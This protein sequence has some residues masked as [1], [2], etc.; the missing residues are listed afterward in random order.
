MA[1]WC[2]ALR[3]S[4]CRYWVSRASSFIW[5]WAR[6]SRYWRW[7][8]LASCSEAAFGRVG[9]GCS[10]LLGARRLQLSVLIWLPTSDYGLLLQVS[11][12]NCFK[13]TQFYNLSSSFKLFLTIL[14]V[15]TTAESAGVGSAQ[16]K[17]SFRGFPPATVQQRAVV[18][19][20]L[21][22]LR[23]A[24]CLLGPPFFSFFC[25]LIPVKMLTGA[26]TIHGR[27][28]R[29]LMEIIADVCLLPL[30]SVNLLRLS[31]SM[32]LELFFLVRHP[33]FPSLLLLTYLT[34]GLRLR[35]PFLLIS[36]IPSFWDSAGYLKLVHHTDNYGDNR[37]PRRRTP[38]KNEFQGHQSFP[39]SLEWSRYFLI[40]LF[41]TLLNN[42]PNS[43]LQLMSPL[44]SS[45]RRNTT[46]TSMTATLSS[47][48][49][50]SSNPPPSPSLLL[51]ANILVDTANNKA[52][53]PIF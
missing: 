25:R 44:P 7:A 53:F 12:L 42:D 23:N 22:L 13:F 48:T 35:L 6:S 34:F 41:H 37:S 28:R 36:R 17:I 33:F 11:A 40:T 49:N 45:I 31:W 39:D 24:L 32:P 38:F 9:G 51:D 21:S 30:R 2:L 5:S 47:M 27:S 43:K 50:P 18:E 8:C 46:R 29:G 16:P 14:I 15:S 19:V 52:N 4:H 1:A 20:S 10:F 26:G 3:L